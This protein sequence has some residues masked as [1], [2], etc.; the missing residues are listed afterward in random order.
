MSK[1][2]FGVHLPYYPDDESRGKQHTQNIYKYLD[3]LDKVYDSV[4]LCDHLIPDTSPI[5]RE[6]LECLTTT[7]Y[8]MPQYP[9]LKF[10]SLVLCNNYRNPALL[11]KMSSSLQVLSEGRYILGIG[12]GWYQEEY[13]QYGYKFLSA[14]KRISQLEE[15]IQ[16]IKLMWTE[17]EVN[18]HGK[19]YTIENTHCNPKPD[20][21]PPIV[22]GGWG[23]TYMLKV[24]ARYAD[25]YNLGFTNVETGIHKLNVLADHCD[26][27]GRDFKDIKKCTVWAIALADS[28]EEAQEIVKGSTHSPENAL[29][30]TP[31]S[32]TTQ[33][34][35]FIDAGIEYFQLYFG[36]FPNIKATQLFADKVIP[37]IT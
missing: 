20:P 37:E 21:L 17:D 34:G 9:K 35:E 29:V 14:R 22:I 24:V 33:I 6:V 3:S 4:W 26:V 28:E 2:K 11:A 18:F 12:A 19:Y 23:E 13:R 8:L 7:S 32:I 16:I 36:L 25:W 31:D 27:V 1:I 10:G 15:A 5:N 30:G